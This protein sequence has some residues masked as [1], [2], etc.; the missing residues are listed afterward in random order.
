MKIT[1]SKLLEIVQEEVKKELE[2]KVEKS[3]LDTLTDEGGA[4]GLDPL[5]KTAKEVQPGV[6]EKDIK[7]LLKKMK[8]VVQHRDGDYIKE[9]VEE[10]SEAHG[11]DSGDAKIL[12]QHATTLDD[13]SEI[14]RIINFILKSNVKVDQTQDVT[15]MKKE[16][17]EEA[18]KSFDKDKMKCNKKRYLRKGESGYGKKQKVVKACDKGKERIVKFGDGKM[19]NKSSSPKNRKNFRSRHNCDNPGSKLKAR[20]WSCKDW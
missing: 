19:K 10:L 7:D 1:K 16:E 17:L 12:R 4:A 3:I 9:E 6:S 20:Y 11:L 14:K 8:K 13:G 5:V 15:K 18:S 2:S